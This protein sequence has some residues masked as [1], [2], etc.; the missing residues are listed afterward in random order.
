MA[1]HA[2]GRRAALITGACGGMGIAC[3]RL[4]GRRHD[5]ILTDVSA[6]RLAASA[7]QLRDEGYAVAAVVPGDLGSTEVLE[8]LRNALDAP[9]RLGPL[10]HTAGLSPVLAGWEAILKVNLVATE[11]LLAMIEPLLSPGAVAVLIASMAGHAKI[12]NAEIDAILDQ[13]LASDF[14]SRMEPHLQRLA[15]DMPHKD[16]NGPAYFLSKRAVI[17][18]CE[19]RAPAWA[20][21]DARIV[22]ISPGV[23]WTPMGRREAERGAAAADALKATP[24]G[25]WGTPIDIAAAAEFLASDLAGFITGCD[26]RVDGGSIPGRMGSTF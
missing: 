24:I 22:S 9:G 11:R 4:F 6:E 15:G 16:P 21:K 18:I 1:D 3:A 7:D 2:G 12:S 19:Q 23:I 13:P 5:L 17:R 25:R 26:L 20:R 10:I 8:Q 14:L